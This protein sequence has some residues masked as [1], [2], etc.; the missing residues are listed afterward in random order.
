MNEPLNIHPWKIKQQTWHVILNEWQMTS[1]QS[2]VHTVLLCI[3][4][5]GLC[6]PLS[7]YFFPFLRVV[8]IQPLSIHYCQCWWSAGGAVRHRRQRSP[9][10]GP[11]QAGGVPVEAVTPTPSPSRPPPNPPSLSYYHRLQV[12]TF[13][14]A[15]GDSG[16]LW[17]TQY[18]HI[19]RRRGHSR[20]ADTWS[21]VNVFGLLPGLPSRAL[22]FCVCECVCFKFI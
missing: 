1:T 20:V 17:L 21:V 11:P 16:T 12:I 14:V 18:L 10:E 22:L 15:F 4:H 8:H 9:C 19:S 2:E 13:S 7:L 3:V 5:R 6:S